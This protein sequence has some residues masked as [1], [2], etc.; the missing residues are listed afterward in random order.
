MPSGSAG[1]YAGLGAGGRCGAD[2]RGLLGMDG[3]AAGEYL[4]RHDDSAP[5]RAGADGDQQRA[6]RAGATPDV[7][8]RPLPDGRR[9]A[10]AWVAVGAGVA[11]PVRP[12]AGR[13]GAGRGGDA[14]GRA[15]GLR[16]LRA[17]GALPD[18]PGHLVTRPAM[19]AAPLT[20]LTFSTW[21]LRSMANRGQ[22]P[23]VG[24]T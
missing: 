6:V 11:R 20:G 22:G 2:R 7:R 8:L 14:D 5:S 1:P 13:P 10:A 19:A 16:R 18:G 3:G 23:P 17:P 9:A 4:R 21:T 15:G 12:P 24:A